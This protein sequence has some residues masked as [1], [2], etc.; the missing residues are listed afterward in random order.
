MTSGTSCATP[1]QTSCIMPQRETGHIL[2][3]GAGTLLESGVGSVNPTACGLVGTWMSRGTPVQGT[4]V[5]TASTQEDGTGTYFCAVQQTEHLKMVQFELSIASSA[6]LYALATDAGYVVGG[7]HGP[8]EVRF[9]LEA[10]AGGQD[11]ANDPRD[12]GAGLDLIDLA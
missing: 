1:E 4:V 6:E 11:H 10:V 5:S 9:G 2:S 3:S 7:D 8:A 12:K